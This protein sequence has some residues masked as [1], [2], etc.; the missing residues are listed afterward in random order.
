M[1]GV[2]ADEVCGIARVDGF[3]DAKYPA[4]SL[5]NSGS[6]TNL[7]PRGASIASKYMRIELGIV[8]LNHKTP[9]Y[10]IDCLASLDG[11]IE[12]GTEVV[13]V[14]NFSNDGSVEK[15]Q[16]AIDARG[17]SW[18]RLA[19][20]PLN[21]GFAYGNNF[22]IRALD[23]DAYI[24]MNCDTIIHPGVV[25][26]LRRAMREHPE[27]GVIGPSYENG[28]GAFEAGAFRD[29]TP[30]GEFVRSAG[31]G[32]IT[33]LLKRW[34]INIPLSDEPREA[35][36]LGFACVL[37]RREVID[38]IGGLDEGYFLYFE[39]M[40]FCR[41]ARNAG[42]KILYWPK[43][44]VMHYMGGFTQVTTREELL[45]RGPRYYYESRARYFTKFHGLRGLWAANALWTLGRA[46]S[47]PREL[48]GQKERIDIRD[49]EWSDIWIN[50]FE[51]NQDTS[52]RTKLHLDPPPSLDH[53]SNGAIKSN[54]VQAVDAHDPPLP[55]GAQRGST[56]LN[57]RDIR[58]I[59]LLLED[60]RTHDSDLLEPGFWA[61]ALHRL[62]NARMDIRPKLLR[63]PATVAYNTI[64]ETINLFCGIHLSHAV[65]VG[66]RVRLWHHG[67][68]LLGAESIGNDVHIRHNTTFGVINRSAIE[69]KPVIE[70]RCDIGTG[71]VIVGKVTV[72]HDSVI[73]ANSVVVRSFPPHSTVFGVP[74]R[75]VNMTNQGV[76]LA[77]TSEANRG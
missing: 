14:D 39:D 64:F 21:G 8:V 66:R 72:G 2:A 76:G 61:L 25:S 59:H 22:G 75:P 68:M 51:P 23:A 50:A 19:P 12:K 4:T 77:T 53:G 56:N 71:V 28:T 15:I 43:P 36:W 46:F 37:V 65:K 9:Q 17:W 18:A 44:R 41:T 27:A 58:L 49:K 31:T 29:P 74:A 40:D 35:E 3:L 57:P 60:F 48:V 6:G 67:G 1:Q 38:Q 11:Q 63:A 24:L 32:I 33:K 16:Q 20:A 10:T 42:W 55:R 5:R 13:V 30:I 73:G 62:G 26:E 45:K 34:D 7:T 54:G 70:D 69:D 47:L 52:P